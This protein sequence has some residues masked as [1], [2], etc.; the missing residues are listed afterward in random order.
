MQ[1]RSSSIGLRILSILAETELS[2]HRLELEVTES[3]LVKNA[4][5]IQGVIDELRAAGIRIALSAFGTDYTTMSQ[6]MAL[7][8]DKIKIDHRFTCRLGIDPQSD[9]LVR[10]TVGFAN[11]LGLTTTAEGIELPSQLDALRA[12]GCAEGQG[13]LF[14]KAVP[15]SEIPDLLG[16]HDGPTEQ[17]A[18][19]SQRLSA[20]KESRQP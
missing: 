7:R 12:T 19:Q 18:A 2:P 17:T 15:A 5:A 8:F 9:A 4:E 1:L 10:A 6:L 16:E 13:F 14:S 11:G 20:T 3:A